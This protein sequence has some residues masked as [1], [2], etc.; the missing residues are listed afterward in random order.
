M[1]KTRRTPSHAYAYTLHTA[2]MHRTVACFCMF[3]YLLALVC[4]HALQMCWCRFVSF[5]SGSIYNLKTNLKCLRIVHSLCMMHLLYLFHCVR[6]RTQ[7]THI[8]MARFRF[9]FIIIYDWYCYCRMHIIPNAATF[10]YRC[11]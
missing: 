9:R 1:L 10:K 11:R 3:T 2:H 8:P 7:S 6:Q 4:L 5:Y